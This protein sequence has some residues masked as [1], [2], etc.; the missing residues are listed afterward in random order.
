MPTHRSRIIDGLL[1]DT[2]TATLICDLSINTDRS[3]WHF[4]ETGLYRTQKGAFFVAGE[5]G[6]LSRW[7]LT[8][9][10]GGSAHHDPGAG[11]EP[12]DVNE[13]KRL[14]E[15]HGSV[16]LYTKLFGKPEEA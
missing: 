7:A 2:E 9:T 3:N 10:G 4:D 6:P 15:Q 5:G 16:E 1:Y 14:I 8:T 13:A 12:V 11:I